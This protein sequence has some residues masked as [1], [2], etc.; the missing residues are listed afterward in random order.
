MSELDTLSKYGTGFQIK[1]L[2]VLLSDREFLEQTQDII[3]PKYFDADGASW[4]AKKIAWYFDKY[5]DIPTAQVFKSE[6]DKE[7]KSEIKSSIIPVLK[8][9]YNN[10]DAGDLNYVKDEFLKF[11]KNQAIKNAILRS[12]D[13]LKTG[14]Y[15]DIKSIITKSMQAGM[16]RNFGHIWKTDLDKRITNAAR[17][18]VPTGWDIVDH[19]TD[20]GIAGGELGV[21][22]APAGIGK[23]WFLSKIGLAALK[24]GKKVLH[25]SYELNENYLGLRYDT[26]LTG[27][28]PN[29]VKFHKEDVEKAI[30]NI[31]GELAIKY[32]PT[33]TVS[34]TS[35][36][37]DVQRRIS[38]GFK[39]DLIIVD[40]ADLMRPTEKS[41]NRYQDLGVIYEDIRSMAGE[42]SIPLWTASQTQ[43]SGLNEAVIE[44]DKIAE[45][46]AKVMT[47]DFIMS[48]SR[49]LEDKI[50]NTAR[51]HVIKNRFG[52]DGITLPCEVNFVNGTVE[53]YDENS[54]KGVLLRRQ[55]QRGEGQIKQMLKQKLME[56]KEQDLVEPDDDLG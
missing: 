44:G 22:M 10:I 5:R 2:S 12:A 11:C 31:T 19:L 24:L 48:V 29:K 38:V 14:R 54:P 37:A 26:L 23:S 56:F 32:F 35:L 20:G 7:E 28:E 53:V 33:R 17:A 55:M 8:D 21:I 16:E 49:Q 50:A 43:R 18:T 40:Y 30:Q 15:D 47:A 39:P 9:V 1:V 4:V 34:A 45:S 42:L 13:Y 41:D 46:F 51:A 36:M 27:I 52:P 3:D 25:Y 6:L